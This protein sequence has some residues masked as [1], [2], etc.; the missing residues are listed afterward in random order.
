MKKQMP[1]MM[2]SQNVMKH[3]LNVKFIFLTMLT[4]FQ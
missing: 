4:T 3:S 1:F 2:M